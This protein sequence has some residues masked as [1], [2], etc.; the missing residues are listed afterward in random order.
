[1]ILGKRK[2]I[3]KKKKLLGL[4]V[5]FLQ[6]RHARVIFQKLGHCFY[7]SS[8]LTIINAVCYKYNNYL[9]KNNS[10]VHNANSRQITD[11]YTE[12]NTL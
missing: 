1:M 8:G 10:D 9:F 7:F 4:C 2:V 3:L 12:R 5:K 11:E 6:L